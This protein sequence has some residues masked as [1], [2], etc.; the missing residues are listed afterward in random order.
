MISINELVT[1][2]VLSRTQFLLL[3]HLVFNI[4]ASHK[5]ELVLLRLDCKIPMKAIGC[6]NPIV[7]YYCPK[8]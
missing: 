2:I 5:Y 6:A 7:N 3:I 8:Q 1:K 4:Q